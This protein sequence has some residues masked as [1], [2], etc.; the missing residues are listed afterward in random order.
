MALYRIGTYADLAI[1]SGHRQD[2]NSY[3]SKEMGGVRRLSALH[4]N[5]AASECRVENEL[6][7][8]NLESVLFLPFCV[9]LPK[10]SSKPTV[11]AA[12]F[13]SYLSWQEW[14]WRN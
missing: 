8:S 7:S 1:W 11:F 2:W 13:K 12:T 3:L 9:A 10:F 14:F 6:Q 5:S 4:K